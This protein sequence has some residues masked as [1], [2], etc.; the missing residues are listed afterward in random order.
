MS[1]VSGNVAPP[2]I[3]R[4]A[5]QLHEILG[6]FQN[7]PFIALDTE[8][9]GLDPHKDKLLLIQFGTATEQVLVDAQAM[10]GSAVQEIFEGDRLVVM[11]NATFDLKMLASHY[12]RELDLTTARVTDTLLSELVLRNGRRT[13]IA[14]QGFALKALA[15][16]YAGMELDKTVREGFYGVIHIG[17]L[18][19]AELR[20]AMRDVEATWKIYAEQLPQ[21]ERDHL[22]RVCGIESAASVA[23]AQM[24]LS[25]A[26]IDVE[27]WKKLVELAKTDT[28]AARKNLDREFRSVSDRD[29]FGNSTLNYDSE[30][31]VL[32][33]LKKM[34]VE[35]TTTRRDVLL[36]SGHPAAKALSEYREHQKIVSTYGDAFLQHVHPVTGRLHPRFSPI[37]A[38]TGRVACSEPNLQNIPASSAF[39]AC[40]RAP[41]GRML[42]TADYVGA[43]LRIIAE[44]SK[45]PVFVRTLSEG[46]DL[47]SIVASQIFQK[48]VSKHENPELRARAKAINFGLAYGMGAQGLANQ[49]DVPLQEAEQ[50]LERYFRAFPRIR[51][52]LNGSARQT[53]QRGVATTLA[54]RRYW[55]I[56][57][58]RDGRDEGTMMRVAKNMPIQGTNADMSKIAMARIVRALRQE[59]LDAFLINM[60]HDELV[61]ESAADVAERVKEIVVREMISGAAE[62]IH[63]VPIEVD[64]KISESWS[65]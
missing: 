57:M 26:P 25:G 30:S 20:Y 8:T 55:F 9:S 39:R 15:S 59:S 22:M 3:L 32:D 36:A 7:A 47:H 19:E 31:D 44:A 33:A 29:L 27:A 54:G 14:D 40:F 48:P 2:P 51:D 11:H 52:Y 46:G 42:I 56:D 13:E 18:S 65:K 12:K 28:V 16:R 38:M 34:G 5:P 60:V 64:A 21:L 10:P 49:I 63:A 41:P 37:G 23:F 17:E 24:E 1:D 35:L 43:E 4:E 45:D 61:V 6:R 62:L 53:L 58:R 50:L